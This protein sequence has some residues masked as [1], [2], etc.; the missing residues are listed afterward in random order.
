M[1]STHDNPID[2]TKQR[3]AIKALSSEFRVPI[4]DMT[5]MYE[6]QLAIMEAGAKVKD[7]IPILLRRKIQD[8]LSH[9]QSIHR[10]AMFGQ[11]V[12]FQRSRQGGVDVIDREKFEVRA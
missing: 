4:D 12:R 2:Q 1:P 5:A 7:Y 6:E 3:L 10:G 9:T 11:N 8:I